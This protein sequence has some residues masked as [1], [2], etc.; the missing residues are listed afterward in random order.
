MAFLRWTLAVLAIF[1][2]AACGGGGTA[3][4]PTATLRPTSTTTPISTALPD[5]ATA[6][7]AGIDADNPIRFV[8]ASDQGEAVADAL[9]AQLS[10]IAEISVEVTFVETQAQALTALCDATPNDATFA[11]LQD[12]SVGAAALRDCGVPRVQLTREVGRESLTGESGVLLTNFELDLEEPEIAIAQLEQHTFCRI[13]LDDLYSWTVPTLLLEANST[14]MAD[15]EDINEVDD[16]DTL[17]AGLQDE[18]CDAIGLTASA[19]EEALDADDTL[20]AAV[21]ISATS[22]DFPFGVLYF[23]YDV[24]LEAIDTL[25]EAIFTLEADGLSN[26]N[27]ETTPEATSEAEAETDS[28]DTESTPEPAANIEFADLFGEGQLIPAEAADFVEL[29]E[30]LEA[31]GLNF[32]L[33]GK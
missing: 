6:I 9:A 14:S 5:V 17:I 22:P 29:A 13:S 10:E 15:F 7:P 21:S 2:L 20:G 28:E 18:S 33:V 27:A 26:V 24:P 19:W 16:I 11:W 12:F 31:T 3:G 23:S 1:F 25:T 30:F 8:I 32:T 4:E